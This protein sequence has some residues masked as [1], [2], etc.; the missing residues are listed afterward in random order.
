MTRTQANQCRME[1]KLF[2]KNNKFLRRCDTKRRKKITTA[3]TTKFFSKKCYAFY[4]FLAAESVISSKAAVQTVNDAI[5]RT[6]DNSLRYAINSNSTMI[7]DAN[8]FSDT[9]TPIKNSSKKIDYMAKVFFF[10]FLDCLLFLH[11]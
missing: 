9:L 8:D 1:F 6:Q 10:F 11:L 2:Y 5:R 4:S 7:F 3:E